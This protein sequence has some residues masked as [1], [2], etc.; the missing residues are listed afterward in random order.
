M[1]DIL[2]YD[3]F[4]GTVIR[5]ESL[6]RRMPGNWTGA[7]DFLL[8]KQKRQPAWVGVLLLLNSLVARGG[9]EPPTQGFSSHDPHDS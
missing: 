7:A 2:P 3:A 9:I 1:T 6:D 4:N 8:G 5:P